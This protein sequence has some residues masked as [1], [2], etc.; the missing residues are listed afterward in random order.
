MCLA[1]GA[2]HFV[3]VEAKMFSGLSSGVTNAP[4]YDQAARTVACI[5]EVLRLKDRR[6][7]DLS[8]LGFYVLAPKA[9]IKRGLFSKQ[10]DRESI[11]A[12]V[13]Q[14]V[15]AYEGERDDWYSEW[16]QPI[17]AQ[18]DIRPASWEDL[19]GE[20]GPH[21]SPSATSIQEFYDRC[22]EFNR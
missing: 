12:K 9:Q 7:S 16:F 18:T 17:L 22:I 20:I 4:Y 2:T 11:R 6:P 13:K 21:D 5:A 14:C 3:V 15:D 19:I 10:L 1:E 8:R